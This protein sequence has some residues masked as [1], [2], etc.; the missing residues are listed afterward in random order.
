MK[1]LDTELAKKLII[2]ITDSN[3]TFQK[4]MKVLKLLD[5]AFRKHMGVF[6]L[7]D[8]ELEDKDVLFRSM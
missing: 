6:Y 3:M 4:K 8:Q 5:E 7:S 2:E 1:E